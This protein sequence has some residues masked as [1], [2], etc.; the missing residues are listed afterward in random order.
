MLAVLP[1]M[2]PDVVDERAG[3]AGDAGMEFAGGVVVGVSSDMEF[4]FSVD[5]IDFG[6]FFLRLEDGDVLPVLEVDPAEIFTDLEAIATSG[7]EGVQDQEVPTV[8]LL[9]AAEDDRMVD[10]CGDVLVEENTAFAEARE[11]EQGGCNQDDAAAEV[12]ADVG[13]DGAVVAEAKSSLPSSTTSSSQE[14]ESRHKSSSKS[15]QGK[16]KAK[17]DWTP[18]LHRRFVQ[19]VEQLGIDKAVPS[20][21]LEIMGIDSLTRH[22]IASHLQKYRSHRKHM[23]AREAEAAS[24]TQRR[25]IYAAGGGA[26]VK[27]PESNV[28]AVPTIGFPP[29]PPPPPPPPAP[30]QHFARPLHVWGHP[31]MDSPRVSMWP[32]R[33][34]LVPHG[35]A[36]PWVSPPPP[37]PSDP[38][39]W[40]HPYMRGPVHMPTQGT[41][42]MAMPMPAARFPAPPV[43]GVLPCPMYR[44]LTTPALS[45]KNQQ[46]AQLQLQAQPSS[47]I[48]DAAIGDVLSKPWLPLPLGL[49]PPSLDSVMGELQ[50]QGVAN[51]P[52]AC[53]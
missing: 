48:I 32:P 24:W 53:G 47:E 31:T 22:N 3:V 44:P 50:R 34:H 17:V 29:P 38:A 35:P 21:I 41:P 1:A 19:A 10:P 25:Q 36:P 7:G 49:K 23:L 15:S 46:D 20:R 40:H 30:M 18:E 14:A 52:P 26:V 16:K 39:F 12:N 8:E 51:V 27:R 33:P 45:S 5:D 6:D 42:C 11:E 2:C 43:P 13:G 37:P 9:A 28:W 4:D